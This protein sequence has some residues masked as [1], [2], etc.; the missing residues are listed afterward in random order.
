MRTSR[1]RIEASNPVCCGSCTRDGIRYST[2]KF[3]PSA[4]DEDVNPWLGNYS[5]KLL[6]TGGWIIHTD[7]AIACMEMWIDR[8]D[9]SLIGGEQLV[10]VT[11]Q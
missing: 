3:I 5:D 2:W 4:L 6:D 7:E 8:K 9:G 10:S 1:G 11:I